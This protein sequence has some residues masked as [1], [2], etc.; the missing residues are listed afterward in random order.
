MYISKENVLNYI[1][2]NV[3]MQDMTVQKLND[4]EVLKLEGH[5]TLKEA[6]K[7]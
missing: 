1:D 5:L 4:D 3:H 7:I 6:G 2:L